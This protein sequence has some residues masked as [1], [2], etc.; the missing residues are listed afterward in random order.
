MHYMLQHIILYCHFTIPRTQNMSITSHDRVIGRV[1]YRAG[2]WAKKWR[3]FSMSMLDSLDCIRRDTPTRGCKNP[4]CRRPQQKTIG[5][6]SKQSILWCSCMGGKVYLAFQFRYQTG[7]AN[8]GKGS[9]SGG[10]GI[11]APFA[12]HVG[13]RDGSLFWGPLLPLRVMSAIRVPA[14]ESV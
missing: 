14:I 11:H 12:R 13:P 2:L 9:P 1:H 10:C 7:S 8:L 5:G 4:C 6:A 3:R